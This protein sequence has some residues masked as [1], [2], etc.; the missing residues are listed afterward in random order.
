MP[1]GVRTF[2]GGMSVLLIVTGRSKRDS[3]TWS[4]NGCHEEVV[5][6]SINWDLVFEV[7]VD[8]LGDAVKGAAVKA[9][10]DRGT[11]ATVDDFITLDER[12]IA[13]SAPVHAEGVRV[14]HC[15]VLSH[16][17]VSLVSEERRGVFA[18]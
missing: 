1:A 10:L 9:V 18:R 13:L 16:K 15:R 12:V 11:V 7:V 3:R 8:Q 4:V 2:L 17:E 14:G 6:V 5:S